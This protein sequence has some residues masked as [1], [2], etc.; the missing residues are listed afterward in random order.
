MTC[1]NIRPKVAILLVLITCKL[2]FIDLF[3]QNVPAKPTRQSSME[4]F[5]AGK[6]ELAYKQF[7]ELLV[8]YPKDPLYKYY[9]GVCLVKLNKEPEEALIL[10]QQ[11]LQGTAAVRSLP[12][13]AVFYLARAQQMSGKFSEAVISFNKFGEQ[14]GKK[15]A[16]E[17]GVPGFIE[18]CNN[19][20]GQVIKPGADTKGAAGIGDTLPSPKRVDPVKE[21]IVQPAV[22][23]EIT[24]NPSL[25][26]D[27]EGVLDEALDFQVKADSLNAIADRQKSGLDSLSQP[28]KVI[29]RNRILEVELLAASFQ[30]K[31]DVKYSEAESLKTG[32][33]VKPKENQPQ[34]EKNQQVANKVSKDTVNN[35]IK[36]KENIREPAKKVE[37]FSVFKVIE[38][39]V[40]TQKDKIPIDPEV[41]AGLI[42]RIQV[43]VFRNP[44]SPSYFKGITP[45]YGFR[46]SGSDRTNYYAGMFRRSSDAA[47]ALTVVKSKGFKDAFV[48]GFSGNKIISAERAAVLEK[49]WGKKPL[50]TN[51][52]AASEAI[53]DTLPPTLTYRVEVTRS[54]KPLKEEQVAEI[55]KVA[56][57]R[58][59]DIQTADD[60]KLIYLIGKFITFESA[61]EYTDLINRNGYRDAKVVAWL[62]KKEIPIETAKQLFEQLK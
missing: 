36:K 61:L 14:S 55:K 2:S 22:Y 60:G 33:P 4:A 51:M 3:S 43:A 31:A 34:K 47:K 56:G 62:G 26:T 6:Y 8:A 37:I 5:S 25:P 58:G 9:T 39:P 29:A 41:P 42:Y 53:R 52:D 35:T 18:Q 23:K 28:E 46:I 19:K 24:A 27:Y 49:E 17:Y 16:K 30:K 21:N 59:M 45:V 7:K 50:M 1:F 57:N 54:L 13:D 32:K 40:F 20:K 11:S 10:L 44:V 15:T 38:K 12:G 48:I